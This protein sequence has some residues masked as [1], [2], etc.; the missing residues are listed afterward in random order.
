ME[1]SKAEFEAATRRTEKLRERHSYA[2]RAYYDQ[3]RNRVVI[4]LANGVEIA[5]DPHQ[6]QGLEDA[7]P[8]DLEDI[9]ITP[10]GLGLYFPKRDADFTLAGLLAGVFGTRKWMAARLGATGGQAKSEKKREASRNNGK[11]GG[12]PKRKAVV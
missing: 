7:A 8:A 12:R 4:E 6:A 11:L 3:A 1:I 9:E 2:V 10:A 5:F